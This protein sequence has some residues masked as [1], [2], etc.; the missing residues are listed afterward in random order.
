[1]VFWSP[2][3]PVEPEHGRTEDAADTGSSGTTREHPVD[4]EQHDHHQDDE[5]QEI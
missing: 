2:K 3:D 5:D 1:M 4:A